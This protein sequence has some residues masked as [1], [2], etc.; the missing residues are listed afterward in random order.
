MFLKD[1]E[2]NRSIGFSHQQSVNLL[3][4]KKISSLDILKYKYNKAIAKPW[5]T[6][7]SM[8]DISRTHEVVVFIK[9]KGLIDKGS[10]LLLPDQKKRMKKLYRR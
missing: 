10:S 6:S 9:E 2:H 1:Y 4:Q 7:I 8:D 3:R 5:I